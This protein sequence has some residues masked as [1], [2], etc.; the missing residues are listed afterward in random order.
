LSDGSTVQVVPPSLF[1]ETASSAG[2]ASPM[3]VLPS[4]GTVASPAASPSSPDCCPPSSPE[5]VVLSPTVASSGPVPP[6]VGPV[7]A[8]PAGGAPESSKTIGSAGMTQTKTENIPREMA[9]EMCGIVSRP[10][11]YGPGASAPA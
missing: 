9:I 3:T 6:S 10:S 2:P 11:G 7:V 1:P 8:S 5:V 4:V